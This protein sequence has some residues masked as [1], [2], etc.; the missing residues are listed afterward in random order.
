[1]MLI[2]RAVC[3]Q[4]PGPSAGAARQHARKIRG[5]C[6]EDGP[7][8]RGAPATWACSQTAC[9]AVCTQRVAHRPH[10]VLCAYRELLLT[11]DVCSCT[12]TLAPQCPT[13]QHM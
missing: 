13:T 4:G 1:M 11:A 7:Q 10:V 9:C 3:R 8:A 6:D 12:V 5:G 2:R